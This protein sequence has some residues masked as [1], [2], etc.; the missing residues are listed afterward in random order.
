MTID[1]LELLLLVIAPTVTSFS[2]LKKIFPNDIYP[3]L[4]VFGGM[5]TLWY[6]ATLIRTSRDK[7]IVD[8]R[9]AFV[10]AHL[11]Y[12]SFIAILVFGALLSIIFK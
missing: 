9:P 12:W 3:I 5:L 7:D 11:L 4:I 10:L 6:F 1:S 2:V 8:G